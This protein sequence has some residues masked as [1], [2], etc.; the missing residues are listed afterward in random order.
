MQQY[1]QRHFRPA[2]HVL[3]AYMYLRKCTLMHVARFSNRVYCDYVTARREV[4]VE[5]LCN[6][7]LWLAG[8]VQHYTDVLHLL[9]GRPDSRH[10]CMRV[11]G[12]W[13]RQFSQLC[14][15]KAMRGQVRPYVW[16]GCNCQNSKRSPELDHQPRPSGRCTPHA[17]LA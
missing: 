12:Q 16:C 2:D 10:P 11:L 1:C 4:C 5:S 15:V 9:P 17:E 6:G 3:N 13:Q 14:D 8:S 7:G